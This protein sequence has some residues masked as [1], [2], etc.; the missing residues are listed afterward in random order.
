MP[1]EYVR[2]IVDYETARI[3]RFTK[4]QNF[5]NRDETLRVQIG[6]T[7]DSPATGVIT[8]AT[9]GLSTFDN[10][11]LTGQDVPLRAELLLSA[12]DRFSFAATGLST[13]AL[14]VASGQYQ[15]TPG[16]IFPHL[17]SGYDDA[18]TTPH[19]LL[20]YPFPW[21]DAFDGLRLDG[22][23]VEW[24][25][26]IPVTADE[27]ERIAQLGAGRRGTGVEAL[28][29]AFEAQRPDIWD[30]TRLSVQF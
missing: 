18:V 1:S 5:L 2:A 25:Y 13:A 26:I 9:I 21:G 4:A 10:H 12:Q 14:N 17:F 3:G 8:F 24:M 28:L 11:L 19:G 7:P 6:Q 20:W 16:V 27:S 23:Q 30:L 15:A 29:D 22:V